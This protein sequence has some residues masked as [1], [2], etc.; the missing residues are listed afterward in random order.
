M[1][2]QHKVGR[3][4]VGQECGDVLESFLYVAGQR[5]NFH[6][7]GGVVVTMYNFAMA[8]LASNHFGKHE[9]VERKRPLVVFGKFVGK[10]ETVR[11]ELDGLLGL[12][13]ATVPK[14]AGQIPVRSPASSRQW[15]GA[16][17]ILGMLRNG[18]RDCAVTFGKH[19]EQAFEPILVIGRVLRASPLSISIPGGRFTA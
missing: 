1:P 3:R 2:V 10:C 6:V 5:R 19:R 18:R 14:P 4:I 7:E 15:Q 11:D 16:M 13:R 17:S 12:R 8:Y 9:R